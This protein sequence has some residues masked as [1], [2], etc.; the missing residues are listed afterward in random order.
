MKQEDIQEQKSL[1]HALS[2]R[3][4]LKGATALAIG[5]TALAQEI[6]KAVPQRKVF[7]YVGTYTDGKSGGNGEGIYLYEMNPQTGELTKIKLAAEIP[8]PAWVEIHPSEKYLYAAN[9]VSNFNGK[10]GSVTAFAINRANG[11][12]KLLNT[13][14]SEGAGPAHLSAEPSGKY[15]FVA[16]YAGGNIAVF[17]ILPGGALGKATDIHQDS[18]FIGA[19]KAASAPEGSFAM[20][21]HDAPHPHMIQAAPGNGFVLHTDLGQDRIY[22][23]RFDRIRGKLTPASTPFVTLP[24]G[25]GPRHFTF[26]PNGQWMYSIQEEASTLSFFHFNMTTGALELEQTLSDLPH[27]FKG[28]NFTSEIMISPDGRFLYAANRLHDTIAIFSIG[29]TNGRM[30]YVGETST[31]GDYPRHFN[32]DT[33]G[34]FLYVCNQHSDSITCFRVQHDTGLLKFTGQYTAVGSPAVITFFS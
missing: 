27:G 21:G 25:D 4:F 28:T 13:V 30:A 8:S 18:G 12:L 19:T 31:L 14:S 23:Y 5:Q 3:G 2:R 17:P 10:N 34:N 26:H 6:A 24:A 32:F 15:V 1:S 9:E 16:N 7:A 29:S 22:I 33:R 20:S 11:D